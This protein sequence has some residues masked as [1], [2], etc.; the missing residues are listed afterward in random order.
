M[1]EVN[2]CTVQGKSDR[3][4]HFELT[5]EGILWNLDVEF[6]FGRLVPAIDYAAGDDSG[7]VAVL[8]CGV[9][10]VFVDVP[11]LLNTYNIITFNKAKITSCWC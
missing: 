11:V 2:H 10:V 9:D 6:Y 1:S 7:C 5:D 3:H 4:S 8:H